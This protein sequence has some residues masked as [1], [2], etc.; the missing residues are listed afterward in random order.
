ME[1]EE[2]QESAERDQLWASLRA[3]LP[4]IEALA[5]GELTTSPQQQQ[6]AQLL[7]RVVLSELQF[8]GRHGV[9]D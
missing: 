1:P 4:A 9:S 5:A 7:A 6:L 3:L 8:R 2:L